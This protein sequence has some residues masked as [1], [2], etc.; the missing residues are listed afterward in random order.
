M[1]HQ[2]Q[3]ARNSYLIAIFLALWLVFILFF[4]IPAFKINFPGLE[5][6]FKGLN[7]SASKILITLFNHLYS[8]ILICLF[9]L[10]SLIIGGRLFKDRLLAIG[11]GFGILGY[12]IFLLGIFKLL[13]PLIIV[14]SWLV[15]L[16]FCIS[17]KS[18]FT[19]SENFLTGKKLK[20]EF[21]GEKV[22]FYI[23]I[24][25]LAVN[26]L[27][28]IIGSLTPE[29][30]YDSLLYHLA[31]PR[32]YLLNHKIFHVSWN[33]FSNYPCLGEM[34]YTFAV[35]V[36][37]DELAK[38]INLSVS[39]LCAAA[40]YLVSCRLFDRRVG[41]LATAFFYITPI[42]S[43]LSW[44]TGVDLFVVF[45]ILLAFYAFFNSFPV[46][47]VALF[48]GLALSCK[49]TALFFIPAFL[50]LYISKKA[51][52]KDIFIF[53]VIILAVFAPWLIKN[54][55]YTGNPLFPHLRNFFGGTVL[56]EDSFKILIAELR[57]TKIRN[58]LDVLKLPWDLTVN[59]PP[60]GRYMIGPMFLFLIPLIFIRGLS[61]APSRAPDIVRSG[62]GT[63]PNYM[64]YIPLFFLSCL[65]FWVVVTQLSRYFL[66]GIAVLSIIL[67]YSC[68]KFFDFK[69]ILKHTI[70]AG[71]ILILGLNICWSFYLLNY[72]FKPFCVVT[73]LQSREEYM[74]YEKPHYPYYVVFKYIN[75][76][77]PEDSKILFV[78]ETRGF[79]SL[80]NFV[81][82]SAFD[83]NPFLEL[84]KTC[85]T[86]V[87]IYENLNKQNFTHILIN[88]KEIR[89]INKTY[90]IFNLTSKQIKLYDDFRENYLEIV[91]NDAD[92]YIFK[93]K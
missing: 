12:L 58:I 55:I 53:V 5:F 52:L 84:L 22:F 60:F 39:V 45:F 90:N 69:G 57:D 41:I 61:R 68:V 79:H 74:M 14:S 56:N 10:S 28:N 78:G 30:F 86:H 27:V 25:F 8:M 35:S 75:E 23:I 63:V 62:S 18:I 15:L 92:T 59:V 82:S 48:A 65:I 83:L 9:L 47:V 49:L 20:E 66:P 31:L 80:R 72:Y 16:L 4:Y 6:G 42:T 38:L 37:G 7:P 51:K 43:T 19:P 11:A 77:L 3:S 76:N 70:F 88:Y 29:I 50:I 21:A 93:I 34:L 54:I 44:T 81:A 13:Y 1:S 17:Y 46:Y 91:F 24:A 32:L 89:R 33:L 26:I 85:K 40:V 87:E 73:G 64:K 2:I 71:I 67:A 36:Q